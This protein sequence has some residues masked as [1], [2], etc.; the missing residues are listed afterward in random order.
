[1][2]DG[3][4]SATLHGRQHTGASDSVVTQR[5]VTALGLQPHTMKKVHGA[6]GAKDQPAFMVDMRLPPRVEFPNLEVTLGDL[7]PG[8]DLLIGMD[9]ITNGDFVV[10][11]R[12]GQTVMSFRVP[13]LDRVDYV[14]LTKLHNPKPKS[15]APGGKGKGRGRG[16]R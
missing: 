9:V 13:S 16:R 6:H 1:M 5:V 15:P 8:S 7:P 10:T 12:G 3:H 2:L 14:H 11:N 4:I